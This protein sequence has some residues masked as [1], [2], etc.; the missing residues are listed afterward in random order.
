MVLVFLYFTGGLVLLVEHD[1]LAGAAVGVTCAGLVWLGA[2]W[3]PRTAALWAGALLAAPPFAA[4]VLALTG[5]VRPA[6][7]GDVLSS[8]EL[9]VALLLLPVPILCVAAGR[10]LRRRRAAAGAP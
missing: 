4:D 8:S 5:L 2:T 6:G 10:G 9:V 7:S 3:E 1:A